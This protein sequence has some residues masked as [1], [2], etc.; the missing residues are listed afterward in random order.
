[1]TE[2]RMPIDDVRNTLEKYYEF[3]DKEFGELRPT[4]IEEFIHRA[5]S[6]S[7]G[8]NVTSAVVL[9]HFE[10][11]ENGSLEYG[12]DTTFIIRLTDKGGAND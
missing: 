5:K 7:E 3:Y 9:Q 10:E 4:S 6:F 11:G 12:K 1:M 2:Q 8:R